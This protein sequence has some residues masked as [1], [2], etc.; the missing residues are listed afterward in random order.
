M[1]PAI[2]YSEFKNQNF[3]AIKANK[4]I[5]TTKQNNINISLKKTFIFSFMTK[6]QNIIEVSQ[7][8]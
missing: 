2:E 5:P 6:L 3:I 7:Q 4:F 8:Y 1:Q